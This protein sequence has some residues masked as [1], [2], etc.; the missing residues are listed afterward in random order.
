MKIKFTQGKNKGKVSMCS[1]TKV[2]LDDKDIT[3]SVASFKFNASPSAVST[4]VLEIYPSEIDIESESFALTTNDFTLQDMLDA[5]TK[6]ATKYI[7]TNAKINM[8]N[9]NIYD[10]SQEGEEDER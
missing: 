5:F 4:V 2:Y 3:D 1:E 10:K 7:I 8:V 6:E 9:N